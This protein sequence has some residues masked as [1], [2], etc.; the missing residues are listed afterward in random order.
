MASIPPSDFATKTLPGSKVV[1]GL[2]PGDTFSTA[3]AEIHRRVVHF[4]PEDEQDDFK[5][6]TENKIAVVALYYQVLKDYLPALDSTSYRHFGFSKLHDTDQVLLLGLYQGLIRSQECK[7]QEFLEAYES[8][9]LRSLIES[10]YSSV[11]ERARG[12]YYKWFLQNRELFD[13]LKPPSIRFTTGEAYNI[14]TCHVCNKTTTTSCGRCRKVWYCSK[15]HQRTD[16]KE[17]KL[18]CRDGQ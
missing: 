12:D 17:H 15:E 4:L 3:P 10:T 11:T 2:H 1:I 14:K 16:W 5:N 13:S 9:E 7:I 8:G 18:V 6:M